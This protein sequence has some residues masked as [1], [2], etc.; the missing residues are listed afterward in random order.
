MI[1]LNKTYNESCFATIKNIPD[2][3]IDLLWFSPPYWD[4]HK[5]SD[6]PEEIGNGQTLEGYMDSLIMLADESRRILKKQG[7][8]VINIMDIVRDSVPVR[9]SDM[10]IEKFG[11]TFIERIVWYIRNKMP[12]AS[13]RRFVNKMEWVLHF[14]LGDDYYF[15]KDLVRLKHSSYAEKDKREWKF[16]SKGKCPGNVWDIKRLSVSGYNKFHI[17]GF[18]PELAN[19]VIKAWCPEKGVV[20][21]PFMG[22]GT[23][24]VIARKL[25]CNFIGSEINPKYCDIANKRGGQAVIEFC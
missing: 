25:G 2:K 24:A 6:S 3:F 15:N 20:Y 19:M 17:A 5:Y 23:T 1:E 22:S 11:L 13:D 4:V 21:D 18:P 9:L 16:N 7:N 8:F 14:A 10:C 12:V